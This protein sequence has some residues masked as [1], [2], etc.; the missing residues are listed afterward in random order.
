[1]DAGRGAGKVQLDTDR[2]IGVTS[3]RQ[4]SRDQIAARRQVRELGDQ[5]RGVGHPAQAGHMLEYAKRQTRVTLDK[6]KADPA[7]GRP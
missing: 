1:M 5:A 4:A 3:R 7:N 2:D 6:I